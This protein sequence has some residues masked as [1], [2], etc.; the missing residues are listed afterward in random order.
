MLSQSISVVHL[1]RHVNWFM[2]ATQ[3]A[4]CTQQDLARLAQMRDGDE[5]D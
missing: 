5:R 4:E 1:L 3:Q 2:R